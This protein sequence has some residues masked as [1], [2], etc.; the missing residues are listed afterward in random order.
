M[1]VP[2]FQLILSSI[3][4]N[5]ILFYLRTFLSNEQKQNSETFKETP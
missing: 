2:E 3:L 5:W 1:F 4:K